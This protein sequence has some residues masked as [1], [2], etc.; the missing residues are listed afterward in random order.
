MENIKGKK[1][2]HLTYNDRLIIARMTK[3][4][5]SKKET[6][7][8]IGC[9]ER[10]I[11]Y[12]LKRCTCEEVDSDLVLHTVYNP[13][14][15]D[16]IYRENLKKK[17]FKSKILKDEKYRKYVSHMIRVHKYSP[18][19]ILYEIQNGDYGFD[20]EIKSVN[21]L[22]AAIDKGYIE[23]VMRS[24]L[25]YRSKRKKHK[26]KIQKRVSRGT[27]IEKRPEKINNKE[28]F[29][30]WEM[31]CVVGKSTNR[32][33]IL[34]LTERKTLKEITLVLKKHTSE[35]VVKALNRLEKEYGSGFY[36]IFKSITVDN[37]CE[38]M[39]F[40]GMQK[41]LRRKGDRTKIYYCHPHCPSERGAN[42]GQN[43][44]IRRFFPKGLDFDKQLTFA[45]L[46]ACEDYI[47]I[48]PRKIFNGCCSDEVFQEELK[49]NNISI[50]A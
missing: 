25:S 27:S 28:E 36:S 41:A 42:E 33:T 29:G 30:H 12:E 35:E 34:A 44:I 13:D 24:S 15:A 32:K 3:L 8:C 26:V 2:H 21:T 45:K 23:G 11:Y 6:A 31:D 19:S 7:N 18:Q 22:Y 37:G 47:N 46:K 4:G 48:Y 20:I 50:P 17:G 40:D 38:F 1:F 49:A 10:T 14:G 5:Y 43:K 39:D 16:V 9:S